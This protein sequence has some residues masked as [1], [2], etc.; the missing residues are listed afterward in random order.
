M[1]PTQT[2][3]LEQQEARTELVAKARE[4]KTLIVSE[5]G[6]VRDLASF[7]SLDLDGVRVLVERLS[8][9]QRRAIEADAAVRKLSQQAVMRGD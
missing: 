3:L 5:M 8:E 1:T 7:L 2:A 4:V 6:S 9:L